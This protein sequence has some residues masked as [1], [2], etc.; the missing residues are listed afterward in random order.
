MFV[1]IS[2]IMYE[3]AEINRF[4][5]REEAEA[6]ASDYMRKVDNGTINGV[7]QAIFDVRAELDIERVEVVTVVKFVPLEST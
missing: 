6:W 1:V 2:E 7:I 3:P 4:A 5:T